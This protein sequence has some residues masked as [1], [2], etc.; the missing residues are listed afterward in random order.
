MEI[1][2][3]FLIGL[4]GSFHCIGMCGPI[5]IAL[6][7]PSTSK[8]KII[9]GRVLYNAGRIVS[10]SF[11]GALFGLFGNRLILYGL[12]QTLS[13]TIGTVI[14][15]YILTPNKIKNK[16]SNFTFYK[17]F[18]ENFQ[19]LFSKSI[20]VKSNLSFFS[21]GVLNGFLPCGFVYIGI[22]GAISTGNFISGTFYMALFGLGTFPI[23]L[24]ASIVGKSLSIR[25]RRKVN[26][27]LPAFGLILAV[28]FILRGLNLG[29][30]FL[31]P[32]LVSQV[33]ENVLC[34]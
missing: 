8:F 20:S 32:K 34:H 5:A 12:Q 28:I 11:M 22:A 26:K 33:Q 7:L 16:I 3:G 23:M 31:S 2:T 14:I 9:F 15:L 6:P 27:L 25:I 21:I 1:W 29:I 10:Y 24:S 19:L 4:L 17:K 18:I 13:I 30:P